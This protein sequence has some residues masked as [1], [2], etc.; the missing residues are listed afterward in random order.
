MRKLAVAVLTILVLFFAFYVKERITR[1]VIHTYIPWTILKYFHSNKDTFVEYP[2]PQLQTRWLYDYGVV[3]ANDDDLLDI[4]TVNH[5]WRQSLL[6][7][8][9]RGGYRDVLTEWGLNQSRDF[10][11]IE[12][13]LTPPSVDKAGLYIYWLNEYL[14]LQAHNMTTLGGVRGTLH[15]FLERAV[16]ENSGFK[17]EATISKTVAGDEG[18][19]TDTYFTFSAAT[20]ALLKLPQSPEYPVTIA[21]SDSMPLSNVFVGNKQVSP[22]SKDFV[23]AL[24]D[25]HAIAWVDYND[26]KRMDLLITRGGM[27]GYLRKLPESIVREVKD[28]LLISQGA[29]E[30]K[31]LALELGISKNACSGRQASWIDFNND[32]LLDLFINC[33]DRGKISGPYPKQL[34]QQMANKK[35]VEVAEE[36]GLQ[37]VDHFIRTFKWLDADND[38]DMDLFAYQD[39]GF[40]LYRNQGGRFFPELV[41]RGKF[42]MND[43]RGLKHQVQPYW[44][45]EG[46]MSVADFDGDGDL[47]VFVASKKGSSFFVN[48]KGGFSFRDPM[49]VGLPREV[50]AAIWSDFNNDG[51]PDLHAVPQGLFVQTKDHKFHETK[52]LM[53]P[54]RRYMAAIVNWFDLDNDG[55]RDVSMALLKNPSFSRWWEFSP[56]EVESWEVMSYRNIGS[57]NHWLQVKLVG[58]PGNYPAIGS[59]VTITTPNGQQTQAVG[60]ND[61]AF[62][63]QGHYRLYFGL[64]RNESVDVLKI[65][66]A[67]GH[68][69]E[70]RNIKSNRLLVIDRKKMPSRISRTRS[71]P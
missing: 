1:E 23:M 13:S 58:G 44:R 69:Q 53:L 59:R 56:K 29:N 6:V 15:A 50:V 57:A 3:D 52:L 39:N 19:V 26:D 33:Q 8:D 31:D 38:G 49:L 61:G 70:F 35:F 28:E 21:L 66:W 40:F 36:A 16:P 41:Y 22:K 17:V 20:D 55:S 12:L 14:I 4:Y 63:S 48:V 10:P 68:V 60:D 64:G 54:L 37:V 67:D 11:D 30:F 42:E 47:D 27:G 65:H 2:L 45:Y 51:L 32:G 62:F 34:Y 18:K 71:T 24:R 46:Q 7:A 5:N 9:G 25:R 43:V